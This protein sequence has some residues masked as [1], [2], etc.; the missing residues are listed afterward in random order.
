M[1]ARIKGRTENDLMKLG[2]KSV[3][4]FRPGF[5][6]ATPGQKNLKSSYKLI[7]WLYPV[8]HMLI[9]NL[10]STMRD[11]GVAMIKCVLKGY[12]KPILEVKDINAL[13]KA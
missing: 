8:M 13:A 10:A 6:K 1:W 4:N 3:Y 11:V 5:M 7:G 12:H 9:P 2:F